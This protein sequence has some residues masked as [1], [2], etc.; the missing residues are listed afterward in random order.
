MN[1]KIN[2]K[3]TCIALAVAQA[4]SIGQVHA[5]TMVVTTPS[6]RFEFGCTFRNAVKAINAASTAGTNCAQGGNF[7]DND[8]IV[9]SSFITTIT[10]E[11]GQDPFT[12]EGRGQILI[13]DN[14]GNSEP[15]NLSI[16]PGGNRVTIRRNS[17]SADNFR[18]FQINDST[19]SFDNV[20]IKNGVLSATNGTGGGIF[21]NNASVA[22]SNSEV[23][24]NSASLLGGGI[25]NT[26]NGSLSLTNSTVSHNTSSNSGGGIF[27][28]GS[29]SL[30][31]SKVSDNTSSALG[32]GINNAFG[33]TITVTDS[34]VSGNSASLG[35]GLS[36]S[37]STVTLTNS[38]VS[39]N[40]AGGGGG[41]Y[42][43]GATTTLNN[44]TVSDNSASLG[45]GFFNTSGSTTTLTNSTVSD[46][47][48]NLYP[49]GGFFNTSS[50]IT[51]INSA[52]TGNSSSGDLAAGGGIDNN[53]TSALTVTNSTISGNSAEGFGGGVSN[54]GKA[55]FVNS[56]ISDNSAN[57]GGGIESIG[58]DS[59]TTITNSMVI[60]NSA[61]NEAEIRYS[62]GTITASNSVFGRSSSNFDPT[63]NPSDNNIVVDLSNININSVLL[64]LGD[65]GGPTLTH[66]L[67]ASSP[68]IDA[69][70]NALCPATDQRGETRNLRCDIGA[71][72]FIDDS[73]FFVIPLPNGRSVIF[74]L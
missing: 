51:L 52:V 7:R 20:S 18:I 71:Y 68:A 66:A 12:N 65:N 1:K 13:Q 54:R 37:L 10:L 32:G 72:E 31:T 24:G 49:G 53:A 15:V 3:K 42:N 56:T 45:G 35:G 58:V 50:S 69:A 21:A 9:F 61:S 59:D 57:G 11:G 28:G 39:G 6:D 47:E 60:G 30:T 38:R 27:N 62:S 63:V 67:P 40:W 34:E 19:V 26:Y 33:G 74:E 70:D 17:F 48:V 5:A 8:T 29:I 14:S 46:N 43:S 44:S 4:W 73:S 23:S 25:Y 55:T 22:L 36:N 2:F 64:P 41:V 16:N